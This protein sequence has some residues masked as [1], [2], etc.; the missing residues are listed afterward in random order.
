MSVLN[1]Q[2]PIPIEIPEE[3]LSIRDT[4]ALVLKAIDADDENT[5]QYLEYL[6][7]S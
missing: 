5:D 1:S 2:D 4:Y 7:E 6:K 3:D